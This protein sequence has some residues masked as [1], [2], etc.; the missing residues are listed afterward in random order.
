MITVHPE[1]FYV[2]SNDSAVLC[3]MLCDFIANSLS[4]AVIIIFFC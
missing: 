1:L 3:L 2:A 4:G